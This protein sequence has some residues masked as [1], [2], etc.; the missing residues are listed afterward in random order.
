MCFIWIDLFQCVEK[1]DQ[2]GILDFG[3]EQLRY[4]EANVLGE[5]GRFHFWIC[6]ACDTF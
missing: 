5:C 1:E 2:G 6:Y 3:P 4:R